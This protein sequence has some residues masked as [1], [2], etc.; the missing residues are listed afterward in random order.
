MIPCTA[1]GNHS[2]SA[3]HRVHSGTTASFNVNPVSLAR[4]PRS[5]TGARGLGVRAP[6]VFSYR[7]LFSPSVS[8]FLKILL[9]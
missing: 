2:A 3:W 4:R 6:P 8:R 5:V 7:W 9:F 1:R